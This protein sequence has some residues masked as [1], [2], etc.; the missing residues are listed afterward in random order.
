MKHLVVVRA[1]SPNHFTAQAV[2]IPEVKAEA[3]TE[4]DALDQVRISLVRWMAGTKLV[5]IDV[6]AK[7]APQAPVRVE[8]DLDLAEYQ[9]ELLRSL[10]VDDAELIA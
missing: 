3:A 1:D 2:G 4:A 9:E 7:A 6:P 8:E 5:R 10:L